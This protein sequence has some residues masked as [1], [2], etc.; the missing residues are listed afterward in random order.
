MPDTKLDIFDSHQPEIDAVLEAGFAIHTRQA[1]GF[2]RAPYALCL[3]AAGGKIIAASKGYSY[4]DDFY[5]SQ[6][7]VDE[8]ARGQG[9]GTRLMIAC[10]DLARRR[11]CLHVWVDTNSYQAPAFY[12]KIGYEERSRIA[13]YRGPYDRIFFRKIL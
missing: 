5:I 7:W 3:R 2:E 4:G 6:L 10:E 12:E 1:A 13:G 8:S 11:G 9:L